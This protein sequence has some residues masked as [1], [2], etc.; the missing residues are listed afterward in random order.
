MSEEFIKGLYVNLNKKESLYE[1]G[2][3]ILRFQ[4]FRKSNLLKVILRTLEVLNEDEE[5]L[6]YKDVRDASIEEIS[7]KY[8]MDVVGEVIKKNPLVKDILCSKNRKI[9]K[10]KI[11]ISY[12]CEALINHI[13]KKYIEEEISSHIDGK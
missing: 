2:L 9:E 11:V 5:L 4:F 1:K 12:G 10:N 8:W 7:S 13:R 6:C 3:K